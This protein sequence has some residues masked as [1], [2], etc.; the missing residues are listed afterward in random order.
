MDFVVFG[1]GVGALLMLAGF[2]LR[3]LGPWLFGTTPDDYA[4]PEFEDAK[5]TVRKQTLASI[6][7]A[8]SAAGAGVAV[9]TIA[10]LLGKT[11]DRIGAIVVGMSLVLAAVGVGAWCYDILRR[12]RAAI[13]IVT[14]QEQSVRTRIQAR[15]ARNRA[16]QPQPKAAN[17]AK[18]KPAAKETTAT[19]EPEPVEA[20]AAYQ[21]IEEMETDLDAPLPD[22]HDEPRAFEAPEP[23]EEEGPDFGDDDED[24]EAGVTPVDAPEEITPAPVA[25][26]P[27]GTTS[28]TAAPRT[29]TTSVPKPAATSAAAK[30]TT[31]AAPK[32]S[33]IK[34]TPQPMD[35]AL[36]DEAV[37][38]E[39]TGSR[40]GSTRN[41]PSWLFDDLETDL[42]R[43]GTQQDDPIDQFRD[44]K[45]V[46][47]PSALERLL[48][49]DRA[50]RAKSGEDDSEE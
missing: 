25:A 39:P 18:A 6:G 7:N 8:I 41:A 9:V 49:E 27:T 29:T 37:R 38:I 24:T 32:I 40:L 10:A 3:D 11:T 45:P 4:L 1:F 16:L 50:K 46:S 34:T 15:D 47:R 2:G 48:A 31:T 14:T 5:K 22:W 35:D 36:I 20:P 28:T 42:E 13:D 33:P 23:P 43:Q 21:D 44:A 30:T 17:A 26:A 19:P 12:Y